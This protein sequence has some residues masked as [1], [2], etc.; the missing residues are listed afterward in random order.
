MADRRKMMMLLG[1][2][3]ALACPHCLFVTSALAGSETAKDHAPAPHWGYNDDASGPEHWGD[4]SPANR[5]CS[6]GFQQ[7]PVDL[8]NE[9][10]AGVGGIDI[11]YRPVPLQVANNGHTIQVN[12]DGAGEIRFDG[13]SYKLLQYHFHHPSE[14]A[15][16][17]KRFDLEVHFVHADGDG[18]LAVLGAFFELGAHNGG[19]RPI[20]DAM[21]KQPGEKSAGIQISPAALLP[22]DHTYYRYYGSLTTPPCSEIVTWSVFAQP[23]QASAPQ[24][25]QFADLFPMN[26][27]PLQRQNRRHILKSS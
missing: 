25:Q 20:W 6:V 9:L 13:K 27:R 8:S 21:P 2:A 14:H 16:N 4:L 19:L 23:L 10:D 1:G 12:C 15:L 26:A 22:D 24:I 3:A 5:V 7:S 18:K 11:T 17:G